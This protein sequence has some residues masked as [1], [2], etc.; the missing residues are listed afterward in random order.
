VFTVVS[1]DLGFDVYEHKAVELESPTLKC[2]VCEFH[3]VLKRPEPCLIFTVRNNDGR[4]V[5][6]SRTF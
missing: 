1:S 3:P 2:R 5:T 6:R 4:S